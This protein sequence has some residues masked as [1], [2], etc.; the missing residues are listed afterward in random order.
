MKKL[1]LFAGC[2][3]LFLN[4]CTSSSDDA[5][6]TPLT[7]SDVLVMKIVESDAVGS[8]FITNYTYNGKKLTGSTDSDGYYEIYTYVG[9]LI[10]SIKTYDSSD[11]LE[12]ALTFTYNTNGKLVTYLLQDYGNNT[13]RRE[14]YVYNSNGTVSSTILTGTPA[15]QTTPRSSAVIQFSGVEVSQIA[16]TNVSPSYTSLQTYTYDVKNNPFRNVIGLD[17]L[18]FIEDEAVGLF[19]NILTDNYTSSLGANDTYTTTYTY[20]D[21]NFPITASEIEGTDTSTIISTQYTYN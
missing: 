7:E 2:A 18:A 6:S 10:T 16:R 20:N 3:A 4:S 5:A 17:K 11:T 1:I 12:Q 13:G 21:L 14:T 9:D 19:H 15:S 8:P